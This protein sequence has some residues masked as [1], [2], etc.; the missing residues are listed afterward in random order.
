MKNSV[1][2]VTYIAMY[3]TEDTSLG[4]T[5]GQRSVTIAPSFTL[6]HSLEMLARF[7]NLKAGIRELS[8]PMAMLSAHLGCTHPPP[9]P[10]LSA[11]HS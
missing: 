5:G 4:V 7:S 1:K 6:R 10:A 11:E 8:F 9:R 2:N 3:T